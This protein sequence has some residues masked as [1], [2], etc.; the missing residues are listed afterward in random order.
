MA[1][2]HVWCGAAALVLGIAGSL[3]GQGPLDNRPD[4]NR[5]QTHLAFRELEHDF[6]RIHD[7]H[8]VEWRFTFTNNAAT[9]ITIVDV[10]TSCGCTK[11][12]LAEKTCQ[13]GASGELV[14]TFNPTNR[15]GKDKKTV[16]VRT[17]E[18]G[19]PR[20]QLAI[21]VDV[22]P[23]IG[24]DPPAVSLGDVRYD[25]VAKS[26]LKR[27]ITITSRVP[28]FAIKSATIDDPRFVLTPQP[29]AQGEADGDKVTLFV[30]QVALPVDIPIGRLQANVRI[31]TNDK[32]RASIVIPVFVEALGEVR[33]TPSP[34]AIQMLPG[35]PVDYVVTIAS[36]AAKPFHIL[37]ATVVDCDKMTLKAEAEPVAG[38]NG[39]SWRVHLRGTSP[40]GGTNVSGTLKLK[41]DLAL[42]PEVSIRFTGFVF[43]V[44][45][46]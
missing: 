16:A 43:R 44:R 37:E 30:F 40:A 35:E 22:I 39:A 17:D 38:N 5:P 46:G 10:H 7:E 33:I 19:E 36:I 14:V 15:Q 21:L 34:V 41:T 28:T 4:G 13:P 24:I 20:T 18:P 29:P 11:T 9:P 25:A 6:G 12:F 1:R 26:N 32:L 3:V 31:E 27:Q 42:E 2:S 23:R 8:T 45:G